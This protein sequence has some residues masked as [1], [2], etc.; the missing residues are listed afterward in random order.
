MD[1]DGLLDRD[2]LLNLPLTSWIGVFLMIGPDSYFGKEGSAKEVGRFVY[3]ATFTNTTILAACDCDDD[4]YNVSL[5][6]RFSS[7]E[8][9]REFYDLCDAETYCE[10][11]RD[12]VRLEDEHL[13]DFSP[14]EQVL[15]DYVLPEINKALAQVSIERKQ[16]VKLYWVTTPDH[17]EDWFILAESRKV[18]GE[19]H[20]QYE[21]YGEGDGEY[22]FAE[23]VLNVPPAKVTDQGNFP[24]HAQLTDLMALGFESF[25]GNGENAARLV[26]YEGRV[27]TEGTLQMHINIARDEEFERRG[28]GRPFGTPSK[29]G[30]PN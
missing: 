20:E 19:F 5:I 30:S 16:G 25:G 12:E 15:P 2:D 28:K 13:E 7:E 4:I 9:K 27:F 8:G 1:K 22:A 10:G 6:F 29:S 17:H 21:G 3:N 11:W 18:A 24:R 26:R 14:L 23:P